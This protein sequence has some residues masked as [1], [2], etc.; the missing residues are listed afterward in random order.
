M[1]KVLLNKLI[2]LI[3]INVMYR[4]M[5]KK[6]PNANQYIN[7]ILIICTYFINVTCTDDTICGINFRKLMKIRIGLLIALLIRELIST[8]H[9]LVSGLTDEDFTERTLLSR[10]G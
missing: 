8:T 2:L 4:M 9:V 6:P 7:T 1:D 10:R 3:H 5:S